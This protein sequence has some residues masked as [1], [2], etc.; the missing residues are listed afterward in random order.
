MARNLTITAGVLIGLLG[1]TAPAAAQLD[2]DSLSGRSRV[3]PSVGLSQRRSDDRSPWT[4]PSNLDHL[5]HLIPHG[6]LHIFRPP[7]LKIRIEPPSFKSPAS[8]LAHEA[9][10]LVKNKGLLVGIG[11]AIA[12]LFGWTCNR[13]KKV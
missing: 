2:P 9:G 6:E 4:D 11:G 3:S 7:P 1:L 8:S 13:G 5:Q 12:G 10:A